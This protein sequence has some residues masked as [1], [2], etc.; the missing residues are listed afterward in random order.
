MTMKQWLAYAKQQGQRVGRIKAKINI[1]A[2]AKVR[3]PRPDE[4]EAFMSGYMSEH[5]KRQ[6]Q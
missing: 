4:H 1:A 5:G 6:K 2:L 3:F